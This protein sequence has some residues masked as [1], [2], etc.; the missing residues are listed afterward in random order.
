SAALQGLTSGSRGQHRPWG[1]LVSSGSASR[2]AMVRPWRALHRARGWA[3]LA[4]LQARP[5]KFGGVSVNL[6]ELRQPLRLERA[7]FGRWLR[8]K[9]RA[10]APGTQGGEGRS[11]SPTTCQT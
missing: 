2:S 7:T 9:C 5:D 11:E 3:A 1:G 8:G 4:G 6:A 10:G